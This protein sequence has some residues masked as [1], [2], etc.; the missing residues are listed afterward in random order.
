MIGRD[1]RLRAI[2]ADLVGMSTIP[3]VTVARHM[4]IKVLAISCVTNMAAGIL[5][6]TLNHEEVLETGRRVQGD[7]VALLRAVL[8]DI[9]EDVNH[10]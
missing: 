2:G 4:G 3:E 7:F 9:A 6:K 8:Q 1:H 10:S 5:D